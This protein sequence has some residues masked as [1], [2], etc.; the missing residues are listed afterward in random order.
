MGVVAAAAAAGRSVVGSWS[1]ESGEFI[2]DMIDDAVTPPEVASTKYSLAVESSK[3][4][5]PEREGEVVLVWGTMRVRR[6]G[7]T[8]LGAKVVSGASV[9][10][11]VLGESG[12][13]MARAGLCGSRAR[14]GQ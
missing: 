4:T 7:R 2:A 6:V 11:G 12:A 5:A 8:R 13:D 1:G 9:G 10:G 3:I 14:G